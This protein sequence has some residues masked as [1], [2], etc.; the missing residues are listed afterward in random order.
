MPFPSHESLFADNGTRVSCSLQ[1]LCRTATSSKH[2]P[3]GWNSDFEGG[4]SNKEGLRT[5]DSL[6]HK[7]QLNL[8][9]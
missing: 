4:A 7:L 9:H 5:V 3:V 8:G 1:P 6:L 2:W